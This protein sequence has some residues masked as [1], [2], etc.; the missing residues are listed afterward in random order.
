MWRLIILHSLV[1]V[2]PQN[3]IFTR[4]SDLPGSLV[5]ADHAVA[6]DTFSCEISPSP[7]AV[8]HP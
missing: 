1:S 5:A 3:E 7:S 2:H 4:G 8:T 6:V